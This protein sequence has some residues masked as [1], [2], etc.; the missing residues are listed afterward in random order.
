[1]TKMQE[2]V[3]INVTLILAWSYILHITAIVRET[4]YDLMILHELGFRV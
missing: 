4:M 2:N 1:M 3:G